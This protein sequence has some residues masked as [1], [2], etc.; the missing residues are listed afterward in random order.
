MPQK[1]KKLLCPTCGIEMNQ[2]AEKLMDPI[3]AEQAAKADPALG[4]LVQE[5]HACPGCGACA[6][7]LAQT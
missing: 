7:R 4:G 5:F 1:P 2:H 6:S 3:N